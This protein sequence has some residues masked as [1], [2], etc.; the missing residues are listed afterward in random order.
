MFYEAKFRYTRR[1]LFCVFI[2]LCAV[3]SI[4]PQQ[5]H[6]L[7]GIES[8]DGQTI[9][10]YR[11][12]AEQY[13]S[14]PIFKFN[15]STGHEQQIMDAHEIYYPSS[16]DIKTVNDFEFFPGDTANFVNVGD[17]IYMDY[18]SY[19]ARNDSVVFGYFSPFY[20]VDISKQNPLKIFVFGDG[21]PVRSWDGGYT[22]PEDSIPAIAD[23]IPISLADFD[24]SVLFG[25]QEL[26][27]FAKNSFP[28]DTAKVFFD[29]YMKILYDVNQFHIYRVNK[30]YG[31][32]SLNVSNNKGNAFTWTKTYPS[33]N[34]IYI[35]IDSTQS[36]VVYLADGRRIY[37]SVNNGYSFSLY[38]S[39]PSKL[40]GIYKKPDSEILYT[41]SKSRIFKVT[42][43]SITVIK[44]LPIPDETFEWFPLAIGNRWVY[45]SYWIEEGWGGP[46][47]YTFVG[48]KVMDV[49][50]DTV[51]E[52]KTYFV[53]ENDY[54][55]IVV[56]PPKM[57]LRVD[58]LT[59]F[60]YRYWEEL[61][62]E[63]IFHNLN[64]EVG[65]TI[66]NPPY[67]E[68]PFYILEYEQQINYLGI[69]TYE[70]MYWENLP[71]G[72][73]HTLVKG[74][75]LA[76]TYFN[77]FGGSENI[78]KGCVISGILY[79]D[80]TNVVD[81]EDEQNSIPTEFKLEQN[82]PNP[83]NPSTKI[84]YQIPVAGN[85][86]LKVFDVLG[87]E[88]ATLVD[89]YKQAGSYNAEFRMQNLELSSGIYFYQLRAGDFVETK[90]MLL[91]K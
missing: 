78:L 87:R 13:H 37:K 85:V 71:C 75:G 51:I 44:S 79:G 74:F 61:N 30:T 67:S 31:G 72:C 62:G 45:D 90:K 2:S 6:F 15:P 34:P 12:G 38:K 24:D 21:G 91:L 25:F 29:D 86:Q 88:I 89:E 35:T 57:F 66:F 5:F 42:P 4:Y 50:K 27:Y 70:R 60:I 59:G 84:N 46:P 10:I 8:P 22:F 77:E 64:A 39:L 14:N 53:V 18:G 69:D 33:E 11:L 68:N 54:I 1:V 41:A 83:F 9:L 19:I 43:D 28:V 23:F 58:S 81:V 52:N 3:T 26:G 16:A 82:Y 20:R 40:I 73:F 48:T 32:Y 47:T 76:R 17:L 36:G 55:S 65:D 7:D 80:T 56:F 63:Y 49:T